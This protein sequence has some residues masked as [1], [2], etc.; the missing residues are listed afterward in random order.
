MEIA[1]DLCSALKLNCEDYY[2]TLP[3]S[4]SVVSNDLDHVKSVLLMPREGIRFKV[5]FTE[6]ELQLTSSLSEHHRKCYRL[7]KYIINGEP[8]PLETKSRIVKYFGNRHTLF[9]SYALKWVAWDHHYNQQCAQAALG[10]CVAKMLSKLQIKTAPV[11]DL[12]H[13]FNRNRII[14]TSKWN[15]KFRKSEPWQLN[16]IEG[17]MRLCTVRRG[18]QK[19][20]NIPIEEYNYETICRAI[21]A[22]GF[23]SGTKRLRVLLIVYI[24]LFTAFNITVLVGMHPPITVVIIMYMFFVT[25]FTVARRAINR[26]WSLLAKRLS[27]CTKHIG[28]W[29]ICTW[30]TTLLVLSVYRPECWG[31]VLMYPIAIVVI[32]L[33]VY[34]CSFPFYLFK[35]AT[36]FWIRRAPPSDPEQ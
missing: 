23:R 7:L 24:F 22:R 33:S 13:P 15:D 9:H 32:S 12:I 8:F 6:A 18:V 29:L 36:L 19:A 5:T 27:L 35:I 4:D 11:E 17:Y 20:L 16:F 1:V 31:P 3:S 26:K 34:G 25:Y 2:S 14:V 21:A 30:I 10:L 28:S